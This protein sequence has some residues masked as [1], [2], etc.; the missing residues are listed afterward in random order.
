MLVRKIYADE[1]VDLF[2]YVV[3]HALE[4][5]VSVNSGPEKRITVEE[6]LAVAKRNRPMASFHEDRLGGTHLFS[7][8]RPE[9]LQLQMQSFGER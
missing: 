7:R 8:L 6:M 3:W 4:C 1:V 2:P 5:E 9:A